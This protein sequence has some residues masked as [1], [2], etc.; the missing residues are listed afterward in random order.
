M[1]V[2]CAVL[3]GLP[4]TREVMGPRFIL[5]KSQEGGKEGCGPRGRGLQALALLPSL[6]LIQQL[7]LSSLPPCPV[8]LWFPA[9]LAAQ[10]LSLSSYF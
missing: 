10:G 4:S 8:Q 1:S 9:L 3:A 7:P 6:D 2:L 5:G